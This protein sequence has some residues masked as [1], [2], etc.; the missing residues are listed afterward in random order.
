MENKKRGGKRVGS[1]RPKNQNKAFLIQC[2]PD[3]I[4]DVREYAKKISIIIEK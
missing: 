4:K 3:K 2:H 1:G